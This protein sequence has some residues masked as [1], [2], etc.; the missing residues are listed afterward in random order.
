MS[1]R[2][3]ERPLS[4]VRRRGA[5]AAPERRRSPRCR[6]AAVAAAVLG[7]VLVVVLGVL[8]GG[9]T[10]S[11]LVYSVLAVAG[12][13]LVVVG[14]LRTSRGRLPWLLMAAGAGILVGGQLALMWLAEDY[15]P[16][17]SPQVWLEGLRTH[18]GAFAVGL[19]AYPLLY[20]GQMVLLRQ[21][22]ERVLPS[23]WLDGVVV[24]AAV[25]A[26]S[27]AFVVPRV[28]DALDLDV[29]G[30]LTLTARPLLGLIMAS[31]AVANW[32]LSGWRSDRR[33]PLVLAAFTTLCASD[34]AGA[35]HVT[36]VLSSAVVGPAVDVGRLA[37]L[38][39]LATAAAAP[40]G[41]RT[42]ARVETFGLVM[43]PVVVLVG[44]VGLLALDE[45]HPVPDAAVHLVL[46]SLLLVGLKLLLVIREV[47][48]LADSRRQA[49]TDDLTG[50]ANR[51]A[52]HRAL[53]SATGG[54]GSAALL[55]LDLDRF[56]EVNDSH[57]HAVGDAL[58]RG[59]ARRA[60]EHLPPTALLARLGGD[61]FAVLL[62]GAGLEEATAVARA[63][64]DATAEPAVV[65]GRP[66]RAVVSVGVAT[67]P[68]AAGRHVDAEE[69]LR[70]ADAAMFLAKR[71]GSDGRGADGRGATG[72]YDE[73]VDAE[74]RDRRQ[75]L[76]ELRATLDGA[77]GAGG[78]LVHYQPQVA[79]ET[80]AVVGAEA[81]V[82]W[83]HP[84]RGLLAPGAF[85]DLVEEHGLMAE[86]TTLV[87]RRAVEDAV[88]WR[89]RGHSLRVSVNVSTSCLV[90]PDLLPL[91]DAVLAESGLDP[92]DLVLEITETTLMEDPELA[93]RT[94]G[95]LTARGVGLSIDDYGTGY[96]S[97]AYLD[98]LPATELKLDRS[99]TV[100][101]LEEG[102]T[103]A[104]VRTT[105]DLAHRLGMRLVAEGVED[106][107]TLRALHE[108]GCDETQ[109]YLHSR[110]LGVEAFTRWLDERAAA[111]AVP[112]PRAGA[113]TGA[114][115]GPAQTSSR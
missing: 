78:L 16:T 74:R 50:L 75:L 93:V 52:F 92:A 34:V 87:L 29:A 56:K 31:L 40:A 58:L 67:T 101:L 88:R 25:A 41:P 79:A 33:L 86:V 51:R 17:R 65:D 113:S 48:V 90:N 11:A 100:R 70:R 35:L 8:P 94:A 81:L 46:V 18:T 28:V 2:P 39:L 110:P 32:A 76:G 1:P 97:M 53:G 106:E 36:G 19:V 61:E 54:D 71:T 26:A 64:V 38:L 114:A 21:R 77:P 60:G 5:P 20:A 24:T 99:F 82:R 30:A 14:G 57:G 89:E 49:L 91:V 62:P 6:R 80:G 85:L 115:T 103:A 63:V 23:A 47:L 3:P 73:A 108:L 95:C 69:L 37:A 111:P 104:I 12:V 107:A 15:D 9:R 10:A 22:V 72:V 112:R 42:A 27:S 84:S 4:P 7:L 44:G 102:R 45:V 105:V 83:Q 43:T 55:L 66:L 98:D 59:T 13:A 68:D 96:A 109:G